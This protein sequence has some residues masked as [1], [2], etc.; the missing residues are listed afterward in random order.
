M[1]LEMLAVLL[2]T[3]TFKDMLKKENVKV[4]IDNKSGEGAFEKG[5]ARSYARNLMAHAF[6]LGAARNQMNIQ[7]MR[8][9]SK[10]NIADEPSRSE[11][12]SMIVLGAEWVDPIIPDVV[13][14]STKWENEMVPEAR[15]IVKADRHLNP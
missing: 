10:Q 6:W 8:V 7:M 2:G 11:L 4:W 3:A 9:A 12:G 5:N 13:W 15:G 14:E 1:A